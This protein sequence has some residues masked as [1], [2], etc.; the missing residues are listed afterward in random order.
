MNKIILINFVQMITLF[1]ISVTN[2][3]PMHHRNFEGN[4]Y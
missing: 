2:A 1:L 4:F 3:V